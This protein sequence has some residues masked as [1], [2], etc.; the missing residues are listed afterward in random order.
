MPP[1]RVIM[2]QTSFILHP[3]GIALGAKARNKAEA[4]AEIG[5]LAHRAYDLEAAQVTA[6]LEARESL[7][8]TGFGRGIAIPHNRME[9]LATPVVLILRPVKPLA[10]DAVDDLPVDFVA[11]LLSP[12]AGGAAHLKALAGLSRMLRDGALLDKLRGAG[13]S[14]SLYA[15]IET[16]EQRNAA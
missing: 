5:A 6:V 15:M 7:G 16:Y 14:D 9:G 10:W 13:D 11:A 2:P 8:S 3:K 1:A 12:I 4:L